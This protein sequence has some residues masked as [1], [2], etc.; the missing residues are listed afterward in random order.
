MGIADQ[1]IQGA[2]AVGVPSTDSTDKQLAFILNDCKARVVVTGDK[3]LTEQALRV[4]PEVPTLEYIIGMSPVTDP[5]DPCVLDFEETGLKGARSKKCV[6]EFE[7]P[8]PGHPAR[9]PAA[10][11]YT[12]AP[13]A[14]QGRVLT[15]QLHDAFLR[16]GSFES[17]FLE[18]ED[19]RIGGIGHRRHA[20]NVLE[21][22]TSGF[23]RRA[24]SVSSLSPVTTTRAFAIVEYEGE[25]LVG[26][27]RVDGDA[28]ARAP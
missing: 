27:G 9:R 15:S 6:A 14:S 13:P 19:A 28:D 16:P 2:R 8:P 23:T 18:I 25:L 10:I 12:R 5:P 11:N 17:R 1:A 3:E 24:C 20:Y 7:R 26:A 22:R 4:K 21:G